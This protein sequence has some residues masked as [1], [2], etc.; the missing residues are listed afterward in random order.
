[1]QTIIIREIVKDTYTGEEGTKVYLKMKEAVS[2]NVKYEI[3]FEDLTPIS[4]SF[5][6]TSFGKFF[7]DFGIEE[8][9]NHL[10][11]V[12]IN[13]SQAIWLKKYFEGYI[14]LSKSA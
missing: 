9:R 6:N 7:N 13:S 2:L 12:N 8:F 3:S 11:I 1:M 10:N 14:S 4:S 5:F